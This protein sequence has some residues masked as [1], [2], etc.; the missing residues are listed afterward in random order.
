MSLPL[1]SCY[2]VFNGSAGGSCPS[3]ELILLQGSPTPYQRP[4]RDFH[5]KLQGM[6]PEAQTEITPQR[7]SQGLWRKFQ[8]KNWAKF[9]ALEILFFRERV[10]L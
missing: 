9:Q 8:C 1:P 10:S 7:C 6:M 4:A 3:W 5:P 2:W